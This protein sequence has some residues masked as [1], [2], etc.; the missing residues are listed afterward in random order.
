MSSKAEAKPVWMRVWEAV[1][2]SVELVGRDQVEAAL[3]RLAVL[4]AAA[5]ELGALEDIEEQ[6]QEHGAAPRP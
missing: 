1:H 6:R 4:E 2:G 3:A 5:R